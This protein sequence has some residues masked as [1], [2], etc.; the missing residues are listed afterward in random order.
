MSGDR[1]THIVLCFGPFE[2]DL[3]TQELRRN[4]VLLRLPG[5]SFQILTILLQRPGQLVSREELQEA[6]WPVDTFVDFEKGINAAVNRLREAL[7][8]SADGPRYVET[9][10][11]RGYR[12]IVP[13]T[14]ADTTV[15]QQPLA[16]P[17]ASLRGRRPWRIALF[18]LVFVLAAGSI[19]LWMT[20]LRAGPAPKV[21]RFTKLTGDGQLKTGPLATDGSRVYINERLPGPRNIVAQVSIHGGETVLLNVPLKQP[22]V[23]D[24]SPDGTELLLANEE[25]NGLSLWVMPATGGSPRRVGADLAVDARFGPDGTSIIYGTRD[26]VFSISRDASVSRKLCSVGHVP[27]AFDYSPDARV[28]RFT[29]F[30]VQLDQMVIL[31][32][33]ADGAKFQMILPGCCGRWTSD[34]RYFVFQNRKDGRLDF[35]TLPPGKRFLWHAGKDKPVQL[36][37]GPMDFQYPLPSRDNR[38]IFAIG[39]S[40]RAELF[41]YDMRTRQFSPFLSGI[42]AEGVSFSQDGQWVAY[43]SFP[44]GALWRSRIDGSDRRQLTFPPLRVFLPRWSPDGHQI[45]FSADLPDSARNVYLISSDGGTPQRILASGQSQADVN[46]S[47]DGNS[48]IFGS[49]FIATAPIYVMDLRTKRIVTLPGSEG[50]FSP[51]YS[52]DGK[53]IAAMRASSPNTLMLYDAA[54]KR[55]TEVFASQVGYPAWSRDGKFLY[56]QRLHNSGAGESIVRLRLSDGKIEEIVDVKNIGRLTAGTFVDWFA[57]APDDSPLFARDI[58]TSEIYA[59]DMD[60][61]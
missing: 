48:L 18:A 29:T 38:Q 56:F 27:F 22:S 55:W 19:A 36:T 23:L 4:G 46:W 2:A 61:P 15:E 57:L 20:F 47:P 14:D 9:L 26:G 40:H 32:S 54:S 28:F 3:Q 13:V 39:T 33:T 53:Y 31:E 30:D 60:W 24:V 51:R 45:A 17:S 37:A 43:A 50:F 35:W 49:L 10:P 6:L 7:C 5:Q 8:D 21:L 42:S 1:T 11:R 52:P 34:G 44:D 16:S 58:S 41:R 59:L 25:E 12:L